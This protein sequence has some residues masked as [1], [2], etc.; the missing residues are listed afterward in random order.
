MENLKKILIFAL[1]IVMA[2]GLTPAFAASPS[3]TNTVTTNV[4]QSVSLVV[5]GN[6]IFGS[7]GIPLQADDAVSGAQPINI[8]STSN[9]PI[10]VSVSATD[11]GVDNGTGNMPISALQWTN[12]T[13]STPTVP[14]TTSG[15]PATALTNMGVP[16]P[17]GVNPSQNVNLDMQVPFGTLANAYNTVVTWTATPT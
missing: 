16:T 1:G 15:T 11:F 13:P 14:M 17:N 8:A 10:N 3:G 7:S 9:V 2:F 5:S 6:A 12:S 4:G